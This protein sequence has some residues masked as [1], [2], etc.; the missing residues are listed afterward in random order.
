M[1]EI[2]HPHVLSTKEA[3]EASKGSARNQKGAEVA[4]QDRHGH[5]RGA[6]VAVRDRH[7]GGRHGRRTTRSARTLAI[8]S[9][10]G[11][12]INEGAP[13]LEPFTGTEHAMA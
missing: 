5:R 3:V 7:D 12:L 1:T 11:A 13:F 4:V 6:G 9:K 10:R 2:V 8:G